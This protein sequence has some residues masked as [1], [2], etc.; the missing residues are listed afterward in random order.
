M[1]EP[2]TVLGTKSKVGKKARPDLSDAELVSLYE[3]MVRIRIFDRRMLALQRQGRIG[4]YGPVKGQ[5][6]TIVA[7]WKAADERDW[8]V[9]AL[10]EGAIAMLRGLPQELAIAQLIGNDLDVC[11]GRQMPCHYTLKEGRYVAMSSVI[12]TQISHATGL[13]MAAKYAKSGEAVLGYL[14][15]GATSANDFHA[16]LNFAAVFKAP[17]V[18]VCQNNQ[19]SI[20]VPF[21]KQTAV[22]NVAIKASAYG[23]P[24]V[25]VDGNDVLATYQVVR[26]ALERAKR[27]DG[28]TLVEAVTYRQLGHSSS[29]DPTRYRDEGKVADWIAKD[30]VERYRRFLEHEGLWDESK[31]SE[32]VDRVD[33]EIAK[34]VREAEAASPVSAD[35]L[36][37]DVFHDVDPRLQEHFRIATSDPR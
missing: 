32:F 1:S 29:D 10:R 2:I 27:G 18:F 3:E 33:G 28:P 35:S 12:G 14:G 17:V 31:E 11:R 4:F 16:G 21:E 7:T 9:P 6:A 24:G 26:D 22:D 37:T 36:I 19:W 23:M 15:D 25:R 30:P 8:I 20:S 5:E 13:A 34:K